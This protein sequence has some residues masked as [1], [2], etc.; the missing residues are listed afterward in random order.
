MHKCI[1]T[2]LKSRFPFRDT[3]LLDLFEKYRKNYFAS[4]IVV[5]INKIQIFRAIGM[6]IAIA[7]RIA[8]SSLANNA[9][10]LP[11]LSL[12]LLTSEGNLNSRRQL[13]LSPRVQLHR[14]CLRALRQRVRI[15]RWAI[16]GKRTISFPGVIARVEKFSTIALVRFRRI[17]DFF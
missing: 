6:S 16:E 15:E 4:L 13:K 2:H 5:I 8:T 17:I 11:V 3:K 10:A 1:F 7:T 12:S 9:F 14:N